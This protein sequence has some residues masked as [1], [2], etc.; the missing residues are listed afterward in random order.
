MTG[1]MANGFMRR[2]YHGILLRRLSS[3]LYSLTL[4]II[5][6]F[7]QIPQSSS[8]RL[9]CSTI[10]LVNV[11]NYST[12]RTVDVGQQTCGIDGPTQYQS[13]D[14]LQSD[15]LT[16]NSSA[17][18]MSF[19][20]SG[21][22]DKNFLPESNCAMN[23]DFNT[24]WQTKNTIANAGGVPEAVMIVAN[25]TDRFEIH[26]VRLIFGDLTST[27]DGRPKA[28]V[29]EKFDSF[30]RSWVPLKYEAEDCSVSFSAVTTTALPMVAY[31][32]TMPAQR[33]PPFF[34]VSTDVY[35]C[36]ICFLL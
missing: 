25:F 34:V 32:A 3:T 10:D 9:E 29:Y 12:F 21:L 20:P 17:P 2:P 27:I 4:F 7:A 18:E 8:Q 15:I 30:T 11:L 5:F 14:P 23:P 31:C 1:A 35:I 36:L 6:T 24:F 33:G 16:C 26:T 19:P 28:V 13:L 22:S